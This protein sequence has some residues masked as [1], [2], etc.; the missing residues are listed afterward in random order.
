MTTWDI[1]MTA[2]SPFWHSILTLI[3]TPKM[4]G[5]FQAFYPLSSKSITQ[6]IMHDENKFAYQV[7]QSPLIQKMNRNFLKSKKY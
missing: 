5:K 2:P 4:I 1:L 6:Y 3:L 7:M